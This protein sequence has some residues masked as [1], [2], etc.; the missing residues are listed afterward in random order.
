MNTKAFDDSFKLIQQRFVANLTNYVQLFEELGGKLRQGDSAIEDTEH[1]RNQMHKLAGSAKTFGFPELNGFAA[2][3]ELVLV[4]ITNGAKQEDVLPALRPALEMFLVEARNITNVH[5]PPTEA[6]AEPVAEVATITVKELDYSIVVVDDGELVRDLV[7]NGLSQEKC[8]IAQADNGFKL[9]QHLEKTKRYSLLTK[10]DLIVLDLNMPDMNGFEVLEKLKADPEF[11]AIPVI[12]L[13]RQ[14][15][16]EAVMQAFSSGAVDYITKPFEV[17][18]LAARIM[19]VLRRDRKTVLIADDDELI[20]DL[21]RQRFFLMGYTVLVARNGTEALARLHADQPDLA[22]LDVVMPGM[23]GLSVLKQSKGSRTSGHI[24]IVMLTERNE[25]ENVL[26]GLDSGAHDY[27][28]K[29]FDIDELAARVS[30][31]L[32][33]QSAGIS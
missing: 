15:E 19:S 14:D 3:V 11:Q 13:T 25:K 8:R 1:Y 23:D 10:P 31:I 2:D 4:K 28:P 33:R 32:R 29:P 30:G 12:M 21:L 9:L 5:T 17:K 27:I 26:M 6:Q 7:I 18:E 22:I 20:S 24:P 16:D